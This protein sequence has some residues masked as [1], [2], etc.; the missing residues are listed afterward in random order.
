MQALAL[1]LAA[2]GDRAPYDR[3]DPDVLIVDTNSWG[4][5]RGQPVWSRASWSVGAR[6]REISAS[7]SSAMD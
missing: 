6:G 1:G 4:A 2:F 7:S 5:I 3:V